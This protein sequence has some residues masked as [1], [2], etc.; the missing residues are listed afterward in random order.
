M[1]VDQFVSMLRMMGFAQN[2]LGLWLYY[3]P[4]STGGLGRIKVRIGEP[5][6]KMHT[7]IGIWGPGVQF[8]N[9]NTVNTPENREHVME[10]IIQQYEALK[11][12]Q[13]H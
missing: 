4:G 1:S 9:Y 11:H 2:D 13:H 8:A 6:W 5:T 3:P 7:H 12:E 10:S